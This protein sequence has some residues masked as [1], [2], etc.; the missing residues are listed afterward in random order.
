MTNHILVLGGGGANGA[1]EAG[2]LEEL[3]IEGWQ[4][5]AVVGTSVGALNGLLVA[6]RRIGDLVPLWLSIRD[7]DIYKRP[8][9]T[10]MGWRLKFGRGLYD[11]TPL[12]R[13]IDR[14]TAVRPT[15]LPYYP[16]FADLVEGLSG[17]SLKPEAVLASASIPMLFPWVRLPSGP[18]V[19]GGVVDNIPLKLAVSLQPTEVTIITPNTK[20]LKQV[21]GPDWQPNTLEAAKRSFQ[22]LMGE[23]LNNDIESFLRINELVRQTGE[24]CP[25]GI[26]DSS[27]REYEYYK[28]NIFRPRFDMGV[29]LDF[30]EVNAKR[31]ISAGRAIARQVLEGE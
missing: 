26:R 21:G 2:V 22:V 29:M 3:S 20:H 24:Y 25:H 6:Q 31:R 14:E 18:A 16:V 17:T 8:H 9:W 30:S 5:D 27:G 11:T 4:Y 7:D 1:F 10:K 15:Q 12:A 23:A 19:D 28:V 13:L